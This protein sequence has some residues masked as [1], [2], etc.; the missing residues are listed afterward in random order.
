MSE[1]LT[2]LQA[3]HD[4]GRYWRLLAPLGYYS[5]SLN[6]VITVPTG[7][8]TNFATLSRGL[9]ALRISLW[10]FEEAVIHDILYHWELVPR[11]A[12]DKV[13]YEALLVTQT[14]RSLAWLVYGLLRVCGRTHYGKTPGCLDPRLSC[15]L[16][17]SSCPSYYFGWRHVLKYKEV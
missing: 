16:H 15:D 1:F 2:K 5:S 3:E 7:Y 11:A 12:A 10:V 8:V 9:N 6:A 13:F 17:C 4:G 14:P